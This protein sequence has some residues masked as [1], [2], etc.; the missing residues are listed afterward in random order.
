M[1]GSRIQGSGYRAHQYPLRS[2]DGKY[3][4]GM[5]LTA[6]TQCTWGA[7]CESGAACHFRCGLCVACFFELIDLYYIPYSA[8]GGP[9]TTG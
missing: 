9:F 5:V 1:M 8:S 3:L 4:Y 2:D 6:P 7:H